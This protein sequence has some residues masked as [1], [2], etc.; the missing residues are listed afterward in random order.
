MNA[1]G[2]NQRRLEIDLPFT[3]TFVAEQMLD[4]GR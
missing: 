4:W 3:Y 2:S 1:D